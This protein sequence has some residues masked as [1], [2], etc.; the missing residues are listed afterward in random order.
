MKEQYLYDKEMFEL[1]A[2]CYCGLYLPTKV[3]KKVIK[4]LAEKDN[5]IKKILNEHKDELKVAHWT[6]CGIYDE[7]G[8]LLEFPSIKYALE[9]DGDGWDGVD[10]RISLFKCQQPK[11][12]DKLYIV[13]NND[14]AEEIAKEIADEIKETLSKKE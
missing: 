6:G 4:V 10:H 11:R 1:S 2:G 13:P 9:Y 8:K 5:Q 12:V 3:M 14:K 7:N